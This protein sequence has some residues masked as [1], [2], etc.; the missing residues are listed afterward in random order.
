MTVIRKN[1]GFIFFI[2][3]LVIAVITVLVLSFMQQLLLFYKTINSVESQHRSFYQLEQTAR[4]LARA[5]ITNLDKHCVRFTDRANEVVQELLAGKGCSVTRGKDHFLYVVEE[6][7]DFLCL[8]NTV[9]SEEHASHHRRV[10]LLLTS[11]DSIPSIL[12]LR[13]L[14]RAETIEPCLGTKHL[15]KLGV[16]S[17]RYLTNPLS[18]H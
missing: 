4:F 15:V 16:S 8:R 12:Q 17:W 7:G 10:S 1:K 9:N 5:K 13:Y 14:S 11:K 3:L 2:T 18:M 6:L